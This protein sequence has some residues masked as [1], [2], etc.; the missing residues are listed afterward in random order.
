MATGEHPFCPGYVRPPFDALAA[1]YPGVD[2]YPAADFRLEWGPIFHRGRLDGSAR[3]LVL[4]QDPA[5]HEAITRRILVG[6]AGQ[7][8]QGLLAKVGITSSYVMVN[9]FLYSVYGQ[10]GGQ[11][12]AADA[13]IGAYRNA[14]LDGLLVDTAV[15]AVVTLGSLAKTAYEQWAQ[16]RPGAA[17]RV[18]LA[19]VRHPTWPESSSRGGGTTLAQATTALLENWNAQLPALRDHVAPDAPGDLRLYGDAWQPGDL[20]EIPEA[21]VPAGCPPWWRSLAAWADRTGPDA[22][23]KRATITVTVPANARP[24]R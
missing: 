4:G 16:T 15:T 14:W 3:L 9:T 6:E 10:G 1:R 21:D 17:E 23:T 19:A 20:V 18:H 12:H 22:E 11:R 24:W 13:G 8:T 2:V 7:R 5:Q